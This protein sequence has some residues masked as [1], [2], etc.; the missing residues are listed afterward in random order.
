MGRMIIGISGRIGAG[1]D[2][3]ARGLIGGCR[4]G[5][6]VPTVCAFADAV[7][8]L[9]HRSF[10][11]PLTWSYGTQADKDRPIPTG[12]GVTV[13]QALQKLG[14]T[15]REIDPDYWVR[16]LMDELDAMPP[17]AVPIITDVRYPNEVDAILLRGG[18]VFRLTRTTSV[19]AHASETSL[20]DNGG[21]G[22]TVIDNRGMTEGEVLEEALGWLY[23]RWWG[24]S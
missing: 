13:R 18:L 17:H 6:R 21:L 1:K 23:R 15:Y 19:D 16:I 10:G 20:T 8:L 5:E 3:L 7:K 12:P 24:W 4:W 11:V 14:Q 9:A 2:T 22:M